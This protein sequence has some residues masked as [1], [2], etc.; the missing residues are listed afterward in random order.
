MSVHVQVLH[1]RIEFRQFLGYR[2]A[3][4]FGFDQHCRRHTILV[5]SRGLAQKSDAA[6]DQN[7]S[8]LARDVVEE[9]VVCKR[10]QHFWFRNC[11]RVR[12]ALEQLRQQG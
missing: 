8:T 1:L 12:H 10:H 11:Q 4:R 6:S 9:S 5:D 7:K 2:D 3:V